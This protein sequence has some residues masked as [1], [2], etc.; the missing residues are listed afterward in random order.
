[1]TSTNH[2]S[3]VV[4]AG[5]EQGAVL[6]I[7]E[8]LN[9]FSI[10]S[11]EGCHLVLSGS[12]VSP[13]HA[14]VML[15]DEGR[16]I[17]S[18]TK[19]RA[20]VYV[21]GDKVIEHV[22]NEGDEISIGPPD[23]PE[24]GRLRFVARGADMHSLDVAAPE[25]VALSDAEELQ[26]APD[27]G[28]S[29]DLGLTPSEEAIPEPVMEASVP[30]ESL[31][32]TPSEESP[33]GDLPSPLAPVPD[34]DPEP[35]P[36]PEPEPVPAFEP[37]REP[38]PIPDLEPVREPEPELGLEALPEP[39]PLPE[40]AAEPT[41][42]APRPARRPDPRKAAPPPMS[43]DVDPLAGLAE[44]LGGDSENRE[45]FV[46]PP[47]E[48]TPAPPPPKTGTSSAVKV[49]RVS[50]L[51]IALAG[52]AW[53]GLQ[54]YSESIVVP[55]VDT[56][57][58]NP[59]EPGQ[60]FTINGSGFG[61]DPDPAIVKVMLGK[62]EVPV[63]DATGTLINMTIPESLGASG[64]QTLSLT[65]A[66]QGS[67]STARLL[68]ITVVPKVA[69]LNP[70]VALSGDEVT[71]TGKWLSSDK[72]KPTVTIAG[73]DAEVLESSPTTIRIKVPE[74][75]ATEGQ[76]VSVKVTVGSEVGKEALLNFGRLPFIES[77]QPARALPG[78][79]VTVTG[80]GLGGDTAVVKVSAR[81]A[82]VLSASDTEVKFSTPG[83]RLSEGAGE[84]SLTIQAADKTSIVHPLEILRE[85]AALY[86]PR[87]FVDVIDDSR[88][89]VACELGPVMVLGNDAP[90][91]KR[92]HDAAARLNT[93]A[94]GGR[95]NRVQFNA[96]DTA[97][98]AAPGGP[99]LVV[100]AGDGSGNSK[101]L[102]SV[103]AAQLT[104]IFDLFLQGRRPSRT[105]EISPEGKAFV[106]IFAAA[107][108]RSSEPGVPQGILL[109]PDP[110]WT[111]A[112][113]ALASAPT[114]DGSQ[115]LALIDGYWAGV[116]EVPGAIQPRKVEISLTVTPSGLVGQK[117]SRQGGLSSD[118]SLRNLSYARRDLR[119]S[120]VDSGEDLNY[121]GRLDGDTIEGN[122][123]KSNGAKVGKL[124]FKLTR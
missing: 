40:P 60:T 113:N 117:T 50:A 55:V 97:I 72:A 68:K 67:T 52:L 35:D 65:V 41:V 106:E 14:S 9:D 25:P 53:F 59:V 13:M 37:V 94:S 91:R 119:F 58:P 42:A 105:V 111:R 54:K 62:T 36:V 15:D 10:G 29:I 101:A 38:D 69:A 118:V 44:S 123:T 77:I 61:T 87:F 110:A 28:S 120:F 64:S 17:V 47:V 108:R 46:P 93:L 85:S 95:E 21:N 7:D 100:S 57:L 92:A 102:A 74:V 73:N 43:E 82:V 79:V 56:Y 88:I 104:D 30:F 71:I 45:R 18:D 76:R 27:P 8:I 115:A 98:M 99:V 109:S 6:L 12:Q 121:Q 23:D 116:I 75:A 112:L 39:E 11:D 19:S 26:A 70:R 84:R 3:V 33:F 103:W 2:P 49:A 80:L 114:L 34:P 1:M 22:L 122:V 78:E 83:L 124:T 90:S 86:S 24:S 66:A 63:L 20:G 96:A 31:G 16:V 5:T 4:V 48:E 32:P 81:S 51:A 107:R 89:V